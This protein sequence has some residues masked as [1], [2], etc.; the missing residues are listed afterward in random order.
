MVSVLAPIASI[1]PAESH[2]TALPGTTG[3]A[4]TWKQ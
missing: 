3:A 2:D 4:I 1:E